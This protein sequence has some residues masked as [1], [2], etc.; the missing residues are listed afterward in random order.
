MLG[1]GER[2]QASIELESVE[3]GAID[4][5]DLCLFG[6]LAA[7]TRVDDGGGAAII[8]VRR[9]RGSALREGGRKETKKKK[10]HSSM[11]TVGPGAGE[12]PK[13]KERNK[14]HKERNR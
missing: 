4:R 9:C 12:K 13:G 3:G 8:L 10:G 2:T 7:E 6:W 5:G 11:D 1:E 14:E